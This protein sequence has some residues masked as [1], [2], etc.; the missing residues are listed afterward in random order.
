MGKRLPHTPRS[1]VRSALRK[2]WLRSRERASALKREGYACEECGAKQSRKK[3][4]EVKVEVH[5]LEGIV[6]WDQMID[7]IYRH[8]LV[9]PGALEV[10]CEDCHAKI[11]EEEKRIK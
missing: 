11:T 6:N 10:V 4:Q 2:L 8:L 5:H 3:G 1:Q 7:Y 9:E